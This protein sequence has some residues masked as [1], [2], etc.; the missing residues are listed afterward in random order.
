MAAS[1]FL[2]MY[3]SCQ[4]TSKRPEATTLKRTN[5]L[6]VHMQTIYCRMQWTIIAQFSVCVSTSLLYIDY[7]VA[8]ELGLR[9]NRQLVTDAPVEFEK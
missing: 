1:H 4:G 8:F 3:L 9:E 6:E 5:G 2:F 7:I